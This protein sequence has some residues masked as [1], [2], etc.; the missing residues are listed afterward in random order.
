MEFAHATRALFLEKLIIS[1]TL[2]IVTSHNFRK[3][4]MTSIPF[5]LCFVYA[6]STIHK[7]CL[8][9]IECAVI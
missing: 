3:H 8:L 9:M 5:Y 6:H 1:S 7:K 2:L 4:L